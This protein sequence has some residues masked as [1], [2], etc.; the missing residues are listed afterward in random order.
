[1]RSRACTVVSDTCREEREAR[2]PSEATRGNDGEV[3]LEPGVLEGRDAAAGGG[4][5]YRPAEYPGVLGTTGGGGGD[6]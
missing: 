4:V 1:M 3:R 2:V 6:G 5:G